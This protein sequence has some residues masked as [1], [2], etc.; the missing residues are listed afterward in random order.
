MKMCS[1]RLRSEDQFPSRETFETNPSAWNIFLRHFVGKCVNLTIGTNQWDKRILEQKKEI[2]A[3]RS[4][5]S[6]RE[7]LIAFRDEEKERIV[8][9]YSTVPAGGTF[10][11]ESL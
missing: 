3:R 11:T 2:I 4:G 5:K 9:T 10:G 6:D 7:I 8:I 1:R